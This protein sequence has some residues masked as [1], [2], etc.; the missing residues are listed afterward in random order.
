MVIFGNLAADV[1]YGVAD[2]RIRTSG[3]VS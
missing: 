1:M 2:P 3:R